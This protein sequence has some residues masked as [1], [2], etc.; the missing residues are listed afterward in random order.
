MYIFLWNLLSFLNMSHLRKSFFLLLARQSFHVFCGIWITGSVNHSV[1][2]YSNYSPSLTFPGWNKFRKI[3]FITKPSSVLMF[4]I[5][6][7]VCWNK[8][9]KS[10]KKYFICRNRHIMLLNIDKRPIPCCNKLLYALH[11]SNLLNGN[12]KFDKNI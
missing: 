3:R 1:L 2:H 5:S 12:A 4:V 7:L 6:V 10:I 8:V 9:E 11:K